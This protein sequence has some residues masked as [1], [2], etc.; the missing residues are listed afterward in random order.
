MVHWK[1][2][3]DSIDFL[4]HLFRKFLLSTCPMPRAILGT[5]DTVLSKTNKVPALKELTFSSGQ[6]YVENPP[7]G[8]SSCL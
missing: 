7:Y 2:V 4:N 8:W 3:K 6:Q 5:S 1:V